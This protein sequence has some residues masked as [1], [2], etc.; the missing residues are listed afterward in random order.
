MTGSNH[1]ISASSTNAVSGT[2]STTGALLPSPSPTFSAHRDQRPP[3]SSLSQISSGMM[4]WTRRGGGG[5]CTRKTGARGG[6]AAGAVPIMRKRFRARGAS[7]TNGIGPASSL[8]ELQSSPLP[9]PPLAAVWSDPSKSPASRQ[10]GSMAAAQPK[11]QRKHADRSSTVSAAQRGPPPLEWKIHTHQARL[12]RPA[13]AYGKADFPSLPP[14]GGASYPGAGLR[15]GGAWRGLEG[16]GGAWRGGAQPAWP[17]HCYGNVPSVH[18]IPR[19]RGMNKGQ[20]G[21]LAGWPAGRG[22]A[23]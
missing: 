18:S 21:S 15:R 1:Q 9:P 16:R 12:W 7:A 5:R 8:Q 4:G 10:R 6:G 20:R 2:E 23:W 11:S 17:L 22:I 19:S 14:L 13:P 3:K